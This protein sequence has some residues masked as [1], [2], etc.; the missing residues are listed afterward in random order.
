MV[1]WHDLTW[2]SHYWLYLGI[3]TLLSSSFYLKYYFYFH[4][5]FS[6]LY[7]FLSSSIISL[8]FFISSLCCWSWFSYWFKAFKASGIISSGFSFNCTLLL[9]ANIFSLIL[10]FC[11][12]PG[13]KIGFLLVSAILGI[14]LSI[15]ET[16]KILFGTSLLSGKINSFLITGFS[17]IYNWKYCSFSVHFALKGKYLFLLSTLYLIS[18]CKSSCFTV[19]YFLQFSSV[20]LP[21]PFS[22]CLLFAAQESL[23]AASG[24]AA[25]SLSSPS[26]YF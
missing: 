14:I 20:S 4:S 13:S 12:G 9:L 6:L 21:S 22:S 26:C 1:Y 15:F 7:S 3:L 24:F 8:W 11:I 25:F 17:I 2:N 10:V 5:S 23:F 19:M 16:K 18:Y